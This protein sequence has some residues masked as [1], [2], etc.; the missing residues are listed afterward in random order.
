M[1]NEVEERKSQC[2]DRSSSGR[3]SKSHSIYSSFIVGKPDPTCMYS[4]YEIISRLLFKP[5]ETSYFY[6][7]L[8]SY[9][10]QKSLRTS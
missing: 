6:P 8:K 2:T 5:K 7:K 10:K 4:M 9:L 3:H 1:Y